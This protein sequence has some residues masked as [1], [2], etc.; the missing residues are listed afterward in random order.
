LHRFSSRTFWVDAIA[1]PPPPFADNR[2][3]FTDLAVPPIRTLLILTMGSENSGPE[4]DM[5]AIATVTSYNERKNRRMATTTWF[6]GISLFLLEMSASMHYLQAGFEQH[7]PNLV[8]LMPTA[9]MLTVRLIGNVAQNLTSIEYALRLLP[10]AVVPLGLMIAGLIF[11]R[12][13]TRKLA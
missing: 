5:A 9:A 10:L 13:A 3:P 8:S 11:E 7:T 12:R 4:A 2:P 6:A 1:D